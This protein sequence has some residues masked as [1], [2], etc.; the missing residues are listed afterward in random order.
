MARATRGSLNSG[1]PLAMASTPVRALQPA[2]NAFRTRKTDTASRHGWRTRDD[3]AGRCRAQRVDETD[4]D[5]GQ[6]AHDEHEGGDEKS[7]GTLPQAPQVEGGDEQ[8]DAQAHLHRVRAG[9]GKAEV[10]GPTPA[11]METAT[12]RV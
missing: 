3:P 6:E 11:A 10:S 12:V 1:T 4:G 7:P 5:D 2:E 8:K 9:G